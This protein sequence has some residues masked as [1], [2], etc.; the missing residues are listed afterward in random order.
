V[1]VFDN[2]DFSQFHCFLHDASW[3]VQF[4]KVRLEQD[5]SDIKNVWLLHVTSNIYIQ[6][7]A[8]ASSRIEFLSVEIFVV[9]GNSRPSL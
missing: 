7:K 6:R 5:L 8:L 9:K 3:R 1:R 4:S 2:E